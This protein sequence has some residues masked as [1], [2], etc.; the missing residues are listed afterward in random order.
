MVALGADL[1]V[2]ATPG[3][4]ECGHEFYSSEGAAQLRDTLAGFDRG[5]IVIAVLG[6][7]FKCPPAPYETAFMLH[8]LLT[9][10]GVREACTITL[11][12]P[13]PKPI[14]I[15]DEVSSAILALCDERRI[16][17]SHATWVDHLDPGER[18]ARLRDGRSLPFDLFLGVPVHRAPR[19]VVDSGLT[20]DGWIA[21]DPATL[22]TKFPDVYA[23]GDVTSAPVPR[24]GVIAEGEASTVAD[25]FVAQVKGAPRRRR[26]PGKS[27]ATWRWGTGPSARST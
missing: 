27:F 5:N 19:V 12:T 7:F 3:L 13:M 6:G 22:A 1:D 2:E 21:V 26:L 8:D 18:V 11:L 9:R 16:E 14:P 10:R 25:V 15:S 20:D 23:V 4:V 17:Y 24:A